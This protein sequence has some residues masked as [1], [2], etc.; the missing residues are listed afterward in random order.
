MSQT[1]KQAG[2]IWK[3]GEM[4]P[5]ERAQVHVMSHALHYGTSVFEG[6][7]AYAIGDKAAILCGRE[8]YERLLFS[9]K[10][11]RIPSPLTVEQ[12]MAVSADT[13][14]ANGLRSAYLRPL[15]Y[16]GAGPRS[17]STRASTRPRRCWPPRPGAPTWAR[18]R[19]RWASTC[20]S[21]AGAATA[22]ARPAPWPRS[23]A[24]T[25]TARRS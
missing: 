5:W 23:A 3:N 14:R 4:L 6:I 16:R 11:A 17:G 2:M 22:P 7:R 21:A 8:H 12:W 18:R 15:V 13:L 20:R 10:V 19:S 25:S 1:S 9:C 24:S